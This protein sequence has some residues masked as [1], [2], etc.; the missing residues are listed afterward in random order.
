LKISLERMVAATK[1]RRLAPAR[2]RPRH[3]GKAPDQVRLYKAAD[4]GRA[5]KLQPD[6]FAPAQRG[7]GWGPFVEPFLRLNA[8]ALEKL[9]VRA[10]VSSAESGVSLSLAPGSRA[11]AIPLRSAQ[12]GHVSGGFLVEPRFG[13]S[14][15]GRL[16]VT[17]GWAASPEILDFPLVP[18]SGREVPPWVLGGPVLH[19]LKELL[20]S[21]RPGYRTKEEVLGRPRGRIVWSRYIT[22]SL[23]RGRWGHLPCRFPDLSTDP[24]LRRIVRWAVAHV[25]DDIAGA[26]GTDFV[27]RHLIAA[28]DELL[29]LLAGVLP[30]VPS[31]SQLDNMT[32]GNP[33]TNAVLSR[34][35]EALAWIVDERG[36]GGGRE[37]DGL[38]WTAPLEVLWE[39]FVEA[40]VRR[41]AALEGGAVRVGRDRETLVPLAWSDPSHRSLGHLIPDIVVTYRDRVEVIDAKYKAHLAELDETGWR[42]FAEDARESHR[43]D[44][45]QILSYASLFDAAEVRAVLVYPLREGTWRALRERNRDRATAELFAGRR[46]VRLELRGLPFGGCASRG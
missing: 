22:E 31:R 41:E 35:L 2:F 46:R 15:V 34:G 25:R 33:A 45:H 14:G 17:T 36:L 8:P 42:A 16:L 12:T 5:I 43:A 1:R 27:A 10:L 11:G 3:A 6:A 40:E 44:V 39:R 32:R 24:L 9:G 7:G 28:A 4:H 38:A 21:L 18:G 26:G 37:M 23:T 20:S 19:R 13:W 29:T 30:L